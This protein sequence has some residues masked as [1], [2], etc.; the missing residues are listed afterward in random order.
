LKALND[1]AT[2][3]TNCLNKQET[4]G[5]GEYGAVS[6]KL[7]ADVKKTHDTVQEAISDL[8]ADGVDENFIQDALLLP[9][10]E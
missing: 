4:A 10:A 5:S 9:I 6:Q 2:I 8:L 7:V 3:F 1:L